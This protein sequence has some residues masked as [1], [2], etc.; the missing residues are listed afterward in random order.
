MV[1][2]ATNPRMQAMPAADEPELSDLP[3]MA[4]KP[5]AWAALID[6]LGFPIVAF[7]AMLAVCVWLYSAERQERGVVRVAFSAE[8]TKLTTAQR[9][10]RDMLIKS[11]EKQTATLEQIKDQLRDRGSR[12]KER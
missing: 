12:G 2:S 3:A 11:L 4:T 6:R 1:R 9:E 7:G 8:I 10:D 5:T